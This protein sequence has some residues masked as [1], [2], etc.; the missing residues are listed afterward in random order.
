M[1]KLQPDGRY[2]A[3]QTDLVAPLT[4]FF[5]GDMPK[6]DSK[7]VE[8]WLKSSDDG[9]TLAK[10][11]PRLEGIAADQFTVNLIEAAVRSGIEE[12]GVPSPQVIHPLRVALTGRTVGPGLFETMAAMGKEKVLYRL[13]AIIAKEH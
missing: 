2:G 10:I 7:A 5:F 9:V 8:K 12:L 1:I 11:L 4:D 3:T 13:K 6:Y